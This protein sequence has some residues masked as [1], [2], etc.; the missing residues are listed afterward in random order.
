M[1]SLRRKMLLTIL[2]PILAL[3]STMIVII[4]LNLDQSIS[5]MVDDYAGRVV[6]QSANVMSEWI[7]GIMKE[8]QLFSERVV[9]RNALK[10]GDWKDLMETDLKARLATRPYY[11]MFF[12]AYPDGSA[13]TTL[14]NIINVADR[15]YFIKIMKQNYSLVVS[16]ALVSKATSKNIFVVAAAVKDEGKTIGVFAAAILLDTI[17]QILQQA[18]LTKG[19][20]VWVCD[21]SGM[22]VADTLNKYALKLNIKEAS[23]MGFSDLEKFAPKIL[24]GESGQFKAKMSDGS[25]IFNHYNPIKAVKGWAFG[26]MIPEK[27]A[28]TDVDR[29]LMIVLIIFAILA[30]LI[31]LIIFFISGTISKPIKSL[32]DRALTFGK[33]DLTVKFE[34]KGR[35]EVAQM[36]QSL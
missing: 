26:V 6:E 34:A 13:P 10:T 35:D 3:L 15:D 18:K 21:S 32:A 7:N 1:K 22:I 36:A 4:Y 16:D 19:T 31:V 30:A 11:E 12:I 17:D 9:V 8:V 2:A 23:K 25:I 33:G 24:S 27:E 28:T 5:R 20:L 29:L 14:G